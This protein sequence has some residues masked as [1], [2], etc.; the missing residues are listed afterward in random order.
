MAAP[1]QKS[2]F[3]AVRPVASAN[4]S[5]LGVV[6]RLVK[7]AQETE[8]EATKQKLLDAAKELISASDAI[9]KALE[10]VAKS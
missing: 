4:T 5:V 8:D 7:Q 9:T 2:L 3:R 6:E 10:A 1:H